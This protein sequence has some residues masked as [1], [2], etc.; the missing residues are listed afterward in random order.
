MGVL[1]QKL[2]AE[3]GKKGGKQMFSCDSINTGPPLSHEYDAR[4]EC[5][6]ALL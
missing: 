1:V 3:G 6:L 5:P 2:K 4:V